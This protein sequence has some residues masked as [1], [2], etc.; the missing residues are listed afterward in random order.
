MVAEGEKIYDRLIQN[1]ERARQQINHLRNFSCL[2]RS[3]IQK[4]GFDLDLTKL[5]INVT[6]TGFAGQKI[7]EILAH[8]FNIQVDAADLFNLIAICGT[9]T[10]KNDLDALVKAPAGLTCKNYDPDGF[11][12]GGKLPKDAW[13]HD[14]L[15]TADGQKYEIKSQGSD[16]KDGGDGSAKDITSND[17]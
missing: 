10:T 16:G 2:T 1:C 8:E 15:Y 7:S 13:D 9:G 6:R 12:K 5:T 17:L 4:K 3:D 14:F 11:I